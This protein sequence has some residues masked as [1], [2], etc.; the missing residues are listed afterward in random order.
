MSVC[1]N[2][3]LYHL[4]LS[5]HLS[6]PPSLSAVSSVAESSELC[7][8]EEAGVSAVHGGT[9]HCHHRHGHQGHQIVSLDYKGTYAHTCA[10]MRT[11]THTW[12]QVHKHAHNIHKHS[13]SWFQ[14]MG[15]ECV[16]GVLW[17]LILYFM[18]IT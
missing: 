17:K 11:H 4:Y 15:I 18:P 14:V 5:L 2:C 8:P 6:L 13:P 10:H 12:T 16:L 1:S 3:F 9:Q 7:G